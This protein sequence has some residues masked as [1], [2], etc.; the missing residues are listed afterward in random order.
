MKETRGRKP[1]PKDKKKSKGIYFKITLAEHSR[2]KKYCNK[3]KISIS[4][5][6]RSAVIIAVDRS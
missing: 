3:K 4:E 6:I 1:L 5:F 2:I